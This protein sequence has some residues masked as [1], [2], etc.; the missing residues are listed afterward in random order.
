MIYLLAY[1]T[2]IFSTIIITFYVGNRLYK[3]G[4]IWLL[5]LFKNNK[6]AITLNKMLRLGY[7]L[8]NIGYIFYAITFWDNS[9]DIISIIQNL[10]KKISAIILLLSYLH[11]QNIVII[12]LM[13]TFN[14]HKKWKLS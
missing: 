13:F 3:D 7:Y 10:S 11:Y 12:K 1:S 6:M 5:D 4:E 9:S 8:V 14:L 2:Y